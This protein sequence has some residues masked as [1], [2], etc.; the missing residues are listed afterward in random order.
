MVA[1][2]GLGFLMKALLIAGLSA[3]TLAGSVWADDLPILTPFKAPPPSAAST[4]DWSGL[5][6]GGHLGVAWGNSHWTASTTAALTPS[7]SG[8]FGLFRPL[9]AFDE[10]GSFLAGLQMGY[11]YV[12][13]KSVHRWR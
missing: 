5:Y 13:P 11:N 10:T 9:N 3:T 8:S 6:A 7:V 1:G 2:R 12:L 4:Y